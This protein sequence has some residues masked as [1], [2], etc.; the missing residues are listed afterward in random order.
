MSTPS[1]LIFLTEHF[2][3]LSVIP[4][5]QTLLTHVINSCTIHLAQI[6]KSVPFSAWR[7]SNYLQKSTCLAMILNICSTPKTVRSSQTNCG[8]LNKPGKYFLHSPWGSPSC[9]HSCCAS[10]NPCHTA[11]PR[12]CFLSSRTPFDVPFLLGHLSLIFL[13]Q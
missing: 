6:W 12:F 9:S 2:L 5:I 10:T 7:A 11:K 1:R 3:T 13:T 8:A 4:I